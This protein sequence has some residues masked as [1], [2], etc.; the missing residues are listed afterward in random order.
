MIRSPGR[1][2]SPASGPAGRSERV[3]RRKRADRYH[4]GNLREAL[5]QEAVRTIRKRGIERVT[6]RAVGEALGVSR[7]ALYRHFVDKSAL[8]AAVAREG[9]RTLRLELL[10]A[11][12]R[13]DQG[14]A[15]FD[16]MG[17][18]YI[19]FAM[20]HPAHYRVMFGGF[21]DKATQDPD[22][23]AEASAAFQALVDALVAQQNAGLVRNDDPL[24]LARFVWATVHGVAMLAIDGQLQGE[25]GDAESLTRYVSERM[26]SGISGRQLSA[27]G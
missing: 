18:A 21:V 9:F 11:W 15:G 5:V 19:R 12:N 22:L 13:G 17:L 6:L 7:T 27:D 14:R 24:Q 3:S 16:A 1:R 26:H 2:G 20:A 25:R 4:H 10:D 8:L 23:M